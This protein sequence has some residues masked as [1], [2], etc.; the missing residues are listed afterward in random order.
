MFLF[1]VL[2]SVIFNLGKFLLTSC[3]VV[4]IAVLFISYFTFFLVQGEGEF[5][6]VHSPS[7]VKFQSVDDPIDLH[8]IPE[9]FSAALG[10]TTQGV[11][12]LLIM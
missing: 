10:F 5:I 2:F 1:A 8:S 7:S 9:V 11:R 6:V 12:K 3:R 4:H